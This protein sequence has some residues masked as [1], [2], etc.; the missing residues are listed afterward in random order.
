MNSTPTSRRRLPSR[1]SSTTFNIEKSGLSYT[2]T[3]SYFENGGLAEIFLANHKNGSHADTSARDAGITCSI[4]LQFGADL[5]T[6]RKALLRD[7]NGN[8][9][10]PL[11]CALDY[12]AEHES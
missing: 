8:P 7:A 12:I 11:G 1:R 4:A 3:A 9:S 2:V 10:G 6:L 5:E